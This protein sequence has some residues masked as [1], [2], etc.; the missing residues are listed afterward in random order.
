MAVKYSPAGKRIW[1]SY[2]D[3]SGSDD[4]LSSVA[5]GGPTSL[6][7]CGAMNTNLPDTQAVVTRIAR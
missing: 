2:K 7:A 3:G 4:M 1:R 6:Y 5:L